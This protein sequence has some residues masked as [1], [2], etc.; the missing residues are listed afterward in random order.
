VLK[1]LE[2]TAGTVVYQGKDI[3]AASKDELRGIRRDL[4]VVFQNPQSSL[5]PDA[6]S[7]RSFAG[8]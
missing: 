8:R 3:T 1:L 2:P 7:D 5:N 6:P 4:Q